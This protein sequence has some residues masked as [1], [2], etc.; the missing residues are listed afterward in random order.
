[1]ADFRVEL[2]TAEILIFGEEVGEDISRVIGPV[3]QAGA[4]G[5]APRLTGRLIDSISW[6]HVPGPGGGQTQLS[7]I[8]YDLFL[9][10]PAKQIHT[11]RR[12]LMDA[13]EF[14]LPKLI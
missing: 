7:A 9:E 11:P 12:T 14:D 2:H 4:K 5:R 10:R 13:L 1:M 3:L 6:R 8:W